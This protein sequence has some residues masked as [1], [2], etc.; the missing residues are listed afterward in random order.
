MLGFDPAEGPPPLEAIFQ[1]IQ[2]DDARAAVREQFERGI[3]DRTDI[4][5]DMNF[6]HPTKGIRNIRSTGHAVL[7]Q[8]GNLREMVG[9]VMD[10]TEH[11]RAEET[12]RR[13]EAYLSEA[14]RLSHTAS[15]GWKVS[16]GELFWSDENFSYLRVRPLCQANPGFSGAARPSKRTAPT[17]KRSLIAPLRVRQN[18]SMPIGCYCLTGE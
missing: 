12:I 6:V 5:L 7:D 11:K 10:L 15:F 3:R 1:R 18:S 14:Q 17:S 9:T 4:E 2:P 8:C 16:S 13:S